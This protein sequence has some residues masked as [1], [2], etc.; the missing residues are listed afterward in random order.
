MIERQVE[1]QNVKHRPDF[2]EGQ[3]AAEAN[4]GCAR[5]CMEGIPLRSLCGLQKARWWDVLHLLL[6]DTVSLLVRA[7][8]GT[9]EST[10]VEW[11][12]ESGLP[13]CERVFH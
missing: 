2:L 9:I 12:P 11:T 13:I 10:R 6:L 7:L 1:T 5:L 8:S 3:H 4:E